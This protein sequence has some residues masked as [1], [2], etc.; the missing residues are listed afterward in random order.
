[1]AGEVSLAEPPVRLNLLVGGGLLEREEGVAMDV[2]C[3]REL[4]GPSLV[5]VEN[6]RLDTLPPEGST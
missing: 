4:E 5:D 2:L 1:M 3:N 6:N